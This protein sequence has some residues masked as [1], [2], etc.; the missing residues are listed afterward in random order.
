M[1]KN[2]KI[3]VVNHNFI[4]KQWNEIEKIIK[5]AFIGSKFNDGYNIIRPIQYTWDNI[6]KPYRKGLKHIVAINEQN[7]IIAACFLV[8][9]EKYEEETSC[10]IGWFFTSPSLSLIQRSR[11]I[12][13]IAKKVHEEVKKAGFLKIVTNMGTK[14][15]AE[16]MNKKHN[17]I[18]EPTKE[19]ENRWVKY[20]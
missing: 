13:A 17:Y 2:Y 4:K 14:K 20:L 5:N 8:P 10:D 15:G 19:Q 9:T 18:L 7:E 1:I 6:H 12:D 16:Y 11:V 3:E